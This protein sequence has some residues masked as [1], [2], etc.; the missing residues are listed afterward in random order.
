MAFAYTVDT[1]RGSTVIGNRRFIVGTFTNG[2]ADSGGAIVTGLSKVDAFDVL[3]TSHVGSTNA[4]RT[5]SGGTVTIVT[6]N[7]VDGTWWAIGN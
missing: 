4:K 1:N 5:V 7:G 2:E 6:P 3:V